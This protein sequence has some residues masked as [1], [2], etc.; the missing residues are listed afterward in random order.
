MKHLP[1]DKSLDCNL[2]EDRIHQLLDDRQD[3]AKDALLG[4]HA[5]K[6]P[7]CEELL[8]TYTSV[9][10]S[11]KILGDEIA[12]ILEAQDFDVTHGWGAMISRHASKLAA[13]AAMLVIALAFFNAFDTHS[14]SPE[15]AMNGGTP[16]FDQPELDPP[17]AAS[18]EPRRKTPDT[19]PFSR[20]FS[21]ANS[22]TLISLPTVPSWDDVTSRLDPIEPMIT[23]SAEIPGVRPMQ[24]SFNAT[25]EILRKSFSKTESDSDPDLGYSIEKRVLVA[26]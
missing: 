13:L 19:S 4:I 14:H 9:G 22:I 5:S 7:P 1:S 24:G 26:A 20:N 8:K 17:L 11:V 18:P 12:Q 10:D 15:L 16:E 21:V 25:L 3:L 2:F 23:Y 6:C